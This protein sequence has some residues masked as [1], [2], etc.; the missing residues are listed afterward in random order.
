SLRARGRPRTR[1]PRR[2]RGAAGEAVAALGGGALVLRVVG[3][4]RLPRRRE[5]AV[6]APA[7]A[8]GDARRRHGGGAT[9]ADRRVP[10]LGGRGRV[11]AVPDRPPRRA[12]AE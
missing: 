11:V 12:P 6:R 9:P 7:R 2:R 10:G 3:L 4:A 8:R 5:A 1:R